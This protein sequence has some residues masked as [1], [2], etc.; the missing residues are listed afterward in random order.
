MGGYRSFFHS[1]PK[2]KATS[3][4]FNRKVNKYLHNG[5]AAEEKLQLIESYKVVKDLKY[6]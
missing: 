2:L 3:I 1:C 6:K 4:S 5:Y